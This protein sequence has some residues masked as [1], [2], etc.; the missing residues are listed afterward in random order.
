MT[1]TE[2]RASSAVR[3]FSKKVQ[4][5]NFQRR[6]LVSRGL[7]FASFVEKLNFEFRFLILLTGHFTTGRQAGGGGRQISH[8][9]AGVLS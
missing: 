3:R 2:A 9:E 4:I 1:G 8:A 7:V 6:N 5:C